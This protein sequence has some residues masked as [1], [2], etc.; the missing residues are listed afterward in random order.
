MVI[1]WAWVSRRWV[2]P[3]LPV[4]KTGSPSVGLFGFQVKW[5]GVAAG[6][7]ASY[8]RTE[9]PSMGDAGEEKCRQRPAEAAAERVV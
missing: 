7:P 5:G 9:A 1:S 2:E 8:R 3:G 6:L 4:T